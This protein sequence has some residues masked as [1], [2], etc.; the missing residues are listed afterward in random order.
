[1]TMIIMMKP[2]Q[3]GLNHSSTHK[4]LIISFIPSSLDQIWGAITRDTL[5]DYNGIFLRF[6]FVLFCLNYWIVLWF[7]SWPDKSSLFIA[8]VYTFSSFSI[9][10]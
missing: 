3:I 1:M 6:F 2:R 9:Y 4:E 10:C 5:Y 7:F 8:T